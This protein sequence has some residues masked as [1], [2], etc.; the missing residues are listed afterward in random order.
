[1]PT[2]EISVADRR[3]CFTATAVTAGLGTATHKHLRLAPG[4]KAPQPVVGKGK[5]TA[6]SAGASDLG[7][8]SSQNYS[9]Y[10]TREV[11]EMAAALL[12][13]HSLLATAATAEASVGLLAPDHLT[14]E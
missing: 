1:M 2:C 4:H 7:I 6:S 8:A 13:Q 12:R 9:D 10:R 11:A 14:T 5:Q 3:N